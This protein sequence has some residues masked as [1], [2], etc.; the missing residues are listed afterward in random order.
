[1]DSRLQTIA[2]CRATHPAWGVLAAMLIAAL[3]VVGAARSQDPAAKKIADAPQTNTALRHKLNAIII[4]RLELREASVREA[5]DFL[6]KKSVELDSAKTGMK[7][8]LKLDPAGSITPVPNGQAPFAEVDPEKARITVAL[9]NIPLIEALRYVTSLAN[10]KFK[11]ENSAVVVVRFDSAGPIITRE[12]TLTP[13]MREVLG[14][15]AGDDLK[16]FLTAAGIGFPAGATVM[17]SPTRDRL[18]MENTQENLDLL[19]DLLSPASLA[20]ARDAEAAGR[21]RIK[22]IQRKLNRIVLPRVEFREATI[23]EAVQFFN[24]K[25]LELDRSEPPQGGIN[26][27]LKLEPAPTDGPPPPA[28]PGLEPLPPGI[29]GLEPAPPHRPVSDL[30]E[31]RITIS[32]TDIPLGEAFRYIAS[33][34]NLR[35]KVESFGLAIVPMNTARDRLIIKELAIGSELMAAIARDG[36]KEFLTARS[37]AF[38][39]GATATWVP[40][41]ARLVLRNTEENLDRAEA[42]VNAD[43]P[44]PL[45][46]AQT[47]A[48]SIMLPWI[49]LRD[50]TLR[51]ALDFLRSMTINPKRE[52]VNLV[53]EP[54]VLKAAGKDARI[55]LTSGGI[56]MWKALRAIAD[57]AG[58]ELVAEPYALVLRHKRATPRIP[59]AGAPG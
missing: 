50:A 46:S 6:Q 23:R 47:K 56:S 17:V 21:A 52:G 32:L 10:L 45:P 12:Y 38:P 14:E 24:R 55:T 2:A 57:S 58:V 59:D 9:F 20:R 51:E 37:I 13:E 3:G 33:A 18:V 44:S 5:L 35:V 16:E 15:K 19:D 25:S 41:R 30:N 49:D 40:G 8:I 53:I 54:D 48:T 22:Q 11:L 26:I 43:D 4:P 1:M 7:I 29:P 28:I 31:R 42:L 27:V 34:A 36:A 39:A